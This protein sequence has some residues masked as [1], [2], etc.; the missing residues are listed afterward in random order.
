MN[1]VIKIRSCAACGHV[2]QDSW[3]WNGGFICKILKI[4]GLI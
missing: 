4:I 3:S 2:K 1:K